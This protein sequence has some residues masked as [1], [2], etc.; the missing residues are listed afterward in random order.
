MSEQLS[1]NLLYFPFNFTKSFSIFY[2]EIAVH[3]ELS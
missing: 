2:I 1:G 3:L